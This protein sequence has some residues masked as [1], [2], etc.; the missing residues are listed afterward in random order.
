LNSTTEVRFLRVA[1]AGFNRDSIKS[2]RGKDTRV[3]LGTLIS[4]ISFQRCPQSVSQFKPSLK[5]L[6]T[7]LYWFH[8]KTFFFDKA[9]L[10]VKVGRKT[11]VPVGGD[12]AF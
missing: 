9:K 8:I 7:M 3:Q 12:P 5:Y 1:I 10:P 2:A 11:T 6:L 4:W